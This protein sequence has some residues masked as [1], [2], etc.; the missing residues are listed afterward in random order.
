M[1]ISYIYRTAK[2]TIHV[3]NENFGKFSEHFI[4]AERPFGSLTEHLIV[5][6]SYSRPFYTYL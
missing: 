4:K 6:F 3:C 5:E 1:A 2:E